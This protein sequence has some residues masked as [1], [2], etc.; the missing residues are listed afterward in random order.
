MSDEWQGCRV[1][2]RLNLWYDD[3]MHHWVVSG[4]DDYLA[5][6][7]SGSEMVRMALTILKNLPDTDENGPPLRIDEELNDLPPRVA[8]LLE[9]AADLALHDSEEMSQEDCTRLAGGLMAVALHVL[10]SRGK[11][12][13]WS[14]SRTP[15]FPFSMRLETETDQEHELPEPLGLHP[16]AAGDRGE[17]PPR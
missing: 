14:I 5:A 10:Q 1:S 13:T 9:S 8:D 17:R 16:S 7:G 15:P 6:M 12:E 3:D 4:K 11:Q 2:S